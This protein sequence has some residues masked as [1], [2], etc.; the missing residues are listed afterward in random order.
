MFPEIQSSPKSAPRRAEYSLPKLVFK[1]DEVSAAKAADDEQ[2]TP[3][4]PPDALMNV[5]LGSSPTPASNKKGISQAPFDDG[6]PSSPPM[7]P[8]YPKIGQE[9]ILPPVA[10]SAAQSTVTDRKHEQNESCEMAIEDTSDTTTHLTPSEKRSDAEQ[11]PPSSNDGEQSSQLAVQADKQDDCIMSDSDV[12]ID[13]PSDPTKI[14]L[15]TEPDNAS[16]SFNPLQS[17]NSPPQPSESDQVTAQLV[18]EMERASSQRSSKED[19]ATKPAQTDGK[20][21]KR[22]SSDAVDV[23]KKARGTP[24]SS[25]PQHVSESPKAREFVAECV[26]INVRNVRQGEGN[27]VA[28]LPQIKRE[29]SQSPCLIEN[30]PL[31]EETLA[32][33]DQNGR[34][35]GKSRTSQLS[36]EALPVVG[37]PQQ[38]KRK[39][40]TDV[41]DASMANAT[42]NS[43]RKSAR[44]TKPSTS[45]PRRPIPSPSDIAV[46]EPRSVTKIGRRRASMRWFWR[47]E[48]SRDDNGQSSA[49]PNVPSANTDD[50]D[51]ATRH[52]QPERSQQLA[53]EPEPA[54]QGPRDGNSGSSP[55]KQTNKVSQ[56]EA[57]DTEPSAG[58]PSADGILQGFRKM[59]NNIKRVALGREEE[60]EMIGI[61]FESVKEVHEAG[62]RN[63][64]T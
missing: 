55:T 5:F 12:F 56:S 25:D 31:E 34:R 64:A 11:A 58:S 63:T 10:D 1:S 48:E 16:T 18:G 60:R 40:R 47:S 2:T 42:E 33:K 21:R 9:T 27:A 61:L 35:T 51:V 50:A 3:V 30:L 8:T 29:R 45:S 28:N 20:K 38:R 44:L 22:T 62:R 4:Y 19:Q 26:L 54:G 52:D 41:D 59:L 17:G 57:I 36:Q 49:N 46:A 37:S 15:A 14:I 53:G 24:A 13:A 6:P 32:T 23:R 39:Q 7:L 43:I